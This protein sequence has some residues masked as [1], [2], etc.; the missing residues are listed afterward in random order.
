MYNEDVQKFY[1]SI[2]QKCDKETW[3]KFIQILRSRASAEDKFELIDVGVFENIV[4]D[5]L[6]LK[7]SSKQKE[8]L[9]NTS[10]R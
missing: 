3:K 7:I 1:F 9:I 6:G 2:Y 4:N 10:G 8:L 5:V